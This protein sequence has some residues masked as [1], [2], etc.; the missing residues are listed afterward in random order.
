MLRITST[1]LRGRQPGLVIGVSSCRIICS[2]RETDLSAANGATPEEPPA[3]PIRSR[4]AR[5]ISASRLVSSSSRARSASASRAVSARSLQYRFPGVRALID[6]F[7]SQQPLPSL[8]QPSAVIRECSQ[9][10]AQRIRA[11]ASAAGVESR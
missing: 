4:G 2:A 6:L 1:H 8:E 7:N 9:S 3:L 11:S 10:A 5:S